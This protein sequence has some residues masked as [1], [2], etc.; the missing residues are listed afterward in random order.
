M[1]NGLHYKQIN[2][3]EDGTQYDY[4]D[5]VA[6]IATKPPTNDNSW[7]EFRRGDLLLFCKGKVIS[8]HLDLI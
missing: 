8:N 2:H 1:W 3:A 5:S 7:I 4:K 6:I